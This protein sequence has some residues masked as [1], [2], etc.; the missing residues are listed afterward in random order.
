M[1][2]SSLSQTFLRFSQCPKHLITVNESRLTCQ[3]ATSSGWLMGGN[4]RSDDD[5]K[6]RLGNSLLPSGSVPRLRQGLYPSLDSAPWTVPLPTVPVPLCFRNTIFSWGGGNG[7]QV[8]LVSGYLATHYGSVNPICISVFFIKFCSFESGVLI[9]I[10]IEI[11]TCICG[12]GLNL[13][14]NEHY[15]ALDLAHNNKHGLLDSHLS[16]CFAS[17]LC[18]E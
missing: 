13:S 2:S 5:K 11:P 6:E 17:F 15:L 8:L 1:P 10:P 14:V 3:F 9:T 7:F 16:H 18:S 12:K 4:G